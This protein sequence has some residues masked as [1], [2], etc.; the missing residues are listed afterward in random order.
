MDIRERNKAIRDKARELLGPY[1]NPQRVGFAIKRLCD[2]LFYSA[3]D[4]C[5]CLDW[6]YTERDGDPAKSR[7]S[8]GI[9]ESVMSEYFEWKKEREHRERLIQEALN[10]IPEYHVPQITQIFKT[11]PPTIQKPRSLKTFRLTGGEVDFRQ[12]Q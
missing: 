3:E 6:W 4:I 7:G 2:E 10:D 11:S 1:Y 5:G 9:V 8:I 12:I